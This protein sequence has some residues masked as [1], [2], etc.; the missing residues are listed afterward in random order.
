[1]ES[2]HLLQSALTRPLSANARRLIS[3]H[4]FVPATKHLI[5]LSDNNNIRAAHWADYQWNAEWTDSSTRLRTFIPN[6][7]TNPPGITLQEEP[8]SGLSASAPV[9]DVSAP[10]CTNGIWPDGLVCGLWVWRRR[11][12]CRPCCPPMSN[13]STFPWTAW[14]D[15]SGRWDNWMA[16]QYLPRDLVRP[17]SDFNN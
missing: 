6:T 12:N 5:S 8:G 13:P 9:S 16:A 10:A 17:S 15:G 1:M 4:P 7:G 3:R 2:G 14:P 11:T